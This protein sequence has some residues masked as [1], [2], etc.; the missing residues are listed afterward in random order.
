[1]SPRVLRSSSW[2]YALIGVVSL[3][4]GAIVGGCSGDDNP[5]GSTIV[6]SQ[7]YRGH[8][9][10]ADS[11]NLVQV[12]PALVG[13]RVDDCQT[14]HTG[15]TVQQ[16]RSGEVRPVDMNPC[17]YCHLIPY[18]DDSVVEGAP[19]G[20]E[21]TLNPFGLAYKNAGRNKDALRDIRG[22]DSDADGSSNDA[23]LQAG[24][25]P[26]DATSM[27][28]QQVAPYITYEFE[29]LTVMT[30]HDQFLLLNSHKQE[31]DTY[32]R[33]VGV[34]V[35]DILAAAGVTLSED[36]SITF[37]APDGYAKDFYY[38]EI[39]SAYP[40][41]LYYSGLDP[42]SFENG[43]QGFVEYP[44]AGQL[45]AGLVD[46]EAIPGQQWLMVAYQRD[47]GDLDASYL[48]PT[49]GRLEGEGPYRNIV[50]Q[51]TPGSP[52]RGSSYSPSGFEDGWDYDDSKDHNAGLCV[53]GIVAI[54][55]NPLPEGYEEFD[56][57]NGGFSLLEKRQLIVYGAGIE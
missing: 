28:G 10:D 1:M 57:K 4:A 22:E 38:E 40:D 27:P 6:S 19:N 25:Y 26:G 16:E 29:D 37:I 56:W 41:G 50:P 30:K 52:D 3:L 32:A 15:A 43:A 18:P 35:V 17:A 14:C 11:N 39:Y 51:T 24:R 2:L 20:Y 48:D 49:S 7:A 36:A 54:R 44:P 12:Y 5:T 47:G 53:R 31:F 13:T 9:N 45:P 21:A 55:V 46:G 42:A 23:E 8:E 34:K 33:Y